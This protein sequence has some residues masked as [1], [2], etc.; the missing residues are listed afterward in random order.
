[1]QSDGETFITAPAAAPATTDC[2]AALADVSRLLQQPPDERLANLERYSRCVTVRFRRQKP[3]QEEIYLQRLMPSSLARDQEV[4]EYTSCAICLVDFGDSEELRRTP[5]AGGH[6]FHPKCLR[7]WL[8]R[9]HTTCPVCR[10]SADRDHGDRASGRPS[11]DAL[12]E[13]V[14]RRMRSGKVDHTISEQNQ[15]KAA[16]V[17]R[18]MREPVYVVPE[19]DEGREKEESSPSQLARPAPML[20]EIFA[21]HI[22]ARKGEKPPAG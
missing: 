8:E 17:M 15:R 13:Y 14:I 5:C 12:A 22:L 9:S 21:A 11:P 20:P 3:T 7:G 1:M 2:V 18:M 10:G 19:D 16:Q 6:A 4:W